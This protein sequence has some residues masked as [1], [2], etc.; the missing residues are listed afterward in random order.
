MT[1]ELPFF[2]LGNLADPM[3]FTEPLNIKGGDSDVL[4]AQLKLMQTIRTVEEKIGDMV[5]AGRVHCPCHLAIGQEA[6]AV[7]VCAALRKSD[8]VFGTH[9]SHAH[10]L[11]L[12]GD[13]GALFAEIQGRVTGCSKGM[14]GSMHLYDVDNGFLGSVPLVSAT[15][16]LA[17]GAA[18]AAKMLGA[19]DIAVA[20]FGDGASEEGVF[21]ES[22]N[23]AAN[24]RL[25]ILFV[26]ENNLFSSHLH[27]NLRQPSD[28]VARFACANGIEYAVIDGND[29]VQVSREANRLVARA[30]EGGGPVFMEL[31]TY[32][33][34]G[35]VGPREDIDV[36]VRRKEDLHLWKQ[37]DPIARLRI[38]LEGEGLLSREAFDRARSEIQDAV[39]EAWD[40][41][42]RAPY[43][44]TT[45]L[46]YLVYDQAGA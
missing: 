46:L 36:G 3:E 33:W 43:P 13:M 14:G 40:R 41:S 19:G 30:R 23:Y 25:P 1:S 18:L 4:V 16:P 8:R 27:I 2:T 11:A 7:G 12:G 34:R 22:L 37:R 28:S 38:A 29:V 35:H 26:C 45:N 32:R 5:A 10:Y 21:H 24:Y 9:R 6:T 39:E 15:I 31:V 17:V 44:E 20:F 42:E